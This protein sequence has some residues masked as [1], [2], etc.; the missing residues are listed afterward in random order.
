ML[1]MVS[2]A[3]A[4]GAYLYEKSATDVALGSAGW[5]ARANDP[6]TIFSNPAGLT[7]LEGAHFDLTLMPIFIN[8]E[9]TPDPDLTTTTGPDGSASGWLPAGGAFY[10]HQLSDT[11]TLGIAAGGYFGL[12]IEYED[13]WVGR[14]YVR[15]AQLQALTLQPAVGIRLSEKWSVG[16]GVAV[17]Y[18]VFNQ[19]V[20]INN[21]PIFLPGVAQPDGE[22]KIDTT[23]TTFQ[24]NL[25]VLWELDSDTRIGLQYLSS[26]KLEFTDTPELTN[27][28]PALETVL[29]LAGVYDTELDVGMEMPQA[30]RFG[31]HTGF[32]DSWRVMADL[33]WEQWSEF[34]KI[35]ILLASD[36]ST[37]LT[38]DRNYEDVWHVAFGAQHDLSDKWELNFGTA[39]DT[40]VVEDRDRTPDLPL[41]P[42]VRLGVGA[43]LQYN[44]KGALVFAYEIASAGD[45]PMAVSRGPLAGTVVG[46]YEGA[47]LHFFAATWR[48][49]F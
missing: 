23:D 32:G 49:R 26:A 11:F 46:D 14:Y 36:D 18:G 35:D 4:G 45:L 47:S 10:S 37:Q 22:L 17:H 20:A 34:G 15:D 2:Y 39:Y 25:G 33:G 38:A 28:R 5:T 16:V 6:S 48:E 31:A 13:T 29:R 40:S 24:G 30:V 42:S 12:A 9:F 27:I 21:T 43:K 41:G 3:W 44:E 19:T 7:R 1:A 8:T